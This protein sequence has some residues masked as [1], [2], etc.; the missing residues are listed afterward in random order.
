MRR[1]RQHVNPLS[2][3]LLAPRE[4][5]ALPDDGRPVEVELGCADA[6]FIIE[7][8]ERERERLFV[9]LDI[10]EV[11]LDEGRARVAARGLDNVRLEACN[12]IVDSAT[13]FAPGRVARFF[14]NFPDPWFKRR[15]KNR[16]WLTDETLAHLVAALAEGGE[17]FFQS[18]V[19]EVALEAF[20]LLEA[21]PALQNVAGEWCFYRGGNPFGVRSTRETIVEEAGLPVWRL[22]F[23]RR[24]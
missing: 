2:L 23:A 8:A 4:P 19:F 18:D 6:R 1:P 20:A 14:I 10:R 12:L 13:L 22:R 9:G 15:T 5:L 16:R 3:H 21:Q 17:I 24:R 11:Y 7:R